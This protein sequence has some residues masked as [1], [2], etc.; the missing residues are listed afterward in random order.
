MRAVVEL[1]KIIGLRM[2]G[3]SRLTG[4]GITRSH[5]YI[6]AVWRYIETRHNTFLAHLRADASPCHLTSVP[7]RKVVLTEFRGNKKKRTGWR[8]CFRFWGIK[9]SG[10]KG[11]VTNSLLPRKNALQG[12]HKARNFGGKK[13]TEL[14]SQRRRVSRKSSICH[15]SAN[16]TNNHIFCAYTKQHTHDEERTEWSK[17]HTGHILNQI[18]QQSFL[19]AVFFESR[20]SNAYANFAESTVSAGPPR[21]SRILTIVPPCT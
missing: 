9:C 14:K 13:L 6:I 10:S 7:A 1:R 11:S 5:I 3:W 15:K 8:R 21:R 4:V 20:T 12:I 19:R 2:I 16:N 18:G 17:I